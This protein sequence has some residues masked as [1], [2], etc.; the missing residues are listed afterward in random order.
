MNGES[1]KV[2]IQKDSNENSQSHKNTSDAIN[3][4][5]S[6]ELEKKKFNKEENK[7]SNIKSLINNFEISTFKKDDWNKPIKIYSKDEIINNMN[8]IFLNYATY[9]LKKKL[10]LISID[11]ITKILKDIGF[12]PELIKLYQIDILIQRVCPKIKFITFEDFMKIFIKIAQKVFP[13]EYKINKDLLL[14][15]FFH[16]IFTLYNIILTEE[17][18]P[19]KDLLKY[20][21]T[22]I[23]SLTNIIPDD[24]QILVLNSLLYTLNE[25]YEKY[26]VKN[27]KINYSFKNNQNLSHFFDFCRDFEIHPYIF[28][29]TQMITYFN[30]IIEKKDLFKLIDDSNEKKNTFTFNNFILFFIHLAEYNYAKI[31]QNINEEE[32][33]VTQLSK[34]IMILTRMECSKGMRAIIINT[35]PNLSLMPNKELLLKYNFIFK[36]DSETFDTFIADNKIIDENNLNNGSEKSEKNMNGKLFDE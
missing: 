36:K 14:N 2:I 12:L 29:E 33:K 8:V 3:Y 16:S 18:I 13:K 27:K 5:N 23:T 7:S 34:L 28:N 24:S 30:T 26:F 4:L 19:I 1:N 17:N 22:S 9:S 32:K 20:S 11:N 10:N 31:Y 25:I 15:H 6:N 21:Y 35:I